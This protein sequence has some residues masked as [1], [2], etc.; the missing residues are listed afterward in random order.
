[1]QREEAAVQELIQLLYWECRKEGIPRCASILPH[2]IPP[3]AAPTADCCFETGAQLQEA[4]SPSFPRA[5][6]HAQ[7]GA[8]LIFLDGERQQLVQIAIPD[9][10][11]GISRVMPGEP[12]TYTVLSE[13]I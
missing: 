12:R 4:G 11:L 13:R 7:Q 1:V 10:G 2:Y 9:G 5:C 3:D 6:Q 8:Q